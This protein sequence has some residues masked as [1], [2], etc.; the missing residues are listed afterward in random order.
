ML[1]QLSLHGTLGPSP[2]AALHEVVGL[3]CCAWQKCWDEKGRE[4]RAASA[5]HTSAGDSVCASGTCGERC[6][7]GRW[8]ER[9]QLWGGSLQV[10]RMWLHAKVG[11]TSSPFSPYSV[12]SPY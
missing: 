7:G 2:A 8:E 1:G 6:L 5:A 11:A 10:A 3:P 9:P 12:A 4:R